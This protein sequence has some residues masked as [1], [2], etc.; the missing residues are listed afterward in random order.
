[1]PASREKWGR[2]EK[3]KRILIIDIIPALSIF[4]FYQKKILIAMKKYI[5]TVLIILLLLTGKQLASQESWSLQR[6]IDYALENNIQIKQQRLSVNHQENQLNQARY[7]RLP[8]LNGQMG[9]NYNYGRS[10]T[11][12]N[13]YENTNSTSLSGSLGTEITLWNG[14]TLQNVIRQRDLDLQA[15]FQDMQ[16]AKDDLILTIAALYLEI[17]F[18]E[19]LSLIDQ[20]QTEITRQQITRTTQLVEAGRLA[21]GALYEIEAQLA[22]EEL[23]LVNGQNR[24][25]L[26]YL[27]LYQLLELPMN[28]S[29]IIDRP[30]LPDMHSGSI[31]YNSIDIFRNAIQSRPEILASQLRIESARRQLDQARGAQFPR[32]SFGANYFNNYN[33]NYTRLTDDNTG[34]REIIPLRDQLT[35]NK[36]YG[37]G[38]SLNIPIFNR[39]QVKTGISNAQLQIMDYE[40]RLQNTRNA[41]QKDIEQA[42]T[43]ALASLKRFLSSEKA[44]AASEEAFRYTEEKYNLGMVTTV[45]YNQMKNNLTIA[46]SQLLQS[47]YEYI[48]RTKILDFYSGVPITL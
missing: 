8:G 2:T 23:Q 48:F 18:A 42:Y 16:K 13:T 41:L 27:N 19:E 5:Q 40:Y 46:Q 21:R 15:S 29:F 22:N 10:L 45:E 11:Y 39:F 24:V 3:Q 9:N 44:V 7:D 30:D 47:R 20:N 37:F 26:A 31:S 25:Q 34:N 6:C 33:N 32:L 1:L 14:F 17:L 36:R 38:L 12:Q 43:N 4:Y 28:Q 35:N